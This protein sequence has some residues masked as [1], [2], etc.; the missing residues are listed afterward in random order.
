MTILVHHWIDLH[1][2]IRVKKTRQN[3]NKQKTSLPANV[4]CWSEY[5]DKHSCIF[6]ILSSQL[7]TLWF[8]HLLTTHN[9]NIPRVT[10]SSQMAHIPFFLAHTQSLVSQYNLWTNEFISLFQF[11]TAPQILRIQIN[12]V[13]IQA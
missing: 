12:Y 3:K 13:H 8:K 9:K 7:T 11:H 4:I 1:F 2:L 10:V 6:C 5:T